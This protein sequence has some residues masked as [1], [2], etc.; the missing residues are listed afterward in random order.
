MPTAGRE[1]TIYNVLS[2]RSIS[3]ATPFVDINEFLVI[4]ELFPVK[5]QSVLLKSV[6]IPLE[7]IMVESNVTTNKMISC[8][9]ID[10]Y[11]TGWIHLEIII[12]IYE[13]N[14]IINRYNLLFK[15]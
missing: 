6:S 10:K 9:T 15:K 4:L 11:I 8:G 2:E 7:R 5:R 14:N 3:A 13:N 1:L 12:Y